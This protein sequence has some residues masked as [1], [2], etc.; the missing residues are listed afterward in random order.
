MIKKIQADIQLH[1]ILGISVRIISIIV[2]Y[3]ILR[4]MRSIS[5]I[6]ILILFG[7]NAVGL[8]KELLF[9]TLGLI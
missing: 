3:C 6:S 1:V 7:M 8:S 2:Y 5:N 4:G 9:D